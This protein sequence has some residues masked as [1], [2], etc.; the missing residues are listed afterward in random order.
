MRMQFLYAVFY[1]QK[2]F[3]DNECSDSQG[4]A[5]PPLAIFSAWMLEQR[6]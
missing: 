5:I 1:M 2:S 4:S 6:L 3:L